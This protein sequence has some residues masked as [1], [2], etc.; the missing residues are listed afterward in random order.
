LYRFLFVFGYL[1]K[2]IATLIENTIRFKP[3]FK[4]NVGRKITYESKETF[5]KE[6]AIEVNCY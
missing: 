4:K 2:I 3:S 6:K 5:S 1:L